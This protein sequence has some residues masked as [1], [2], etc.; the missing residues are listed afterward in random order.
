LRNLL[1]NALNYTDSG[2]QITLSAA[3]IGEEVVLSITDTGTGIPP[4]HLPHIFEK[5]SRVPG[6]SRGSGTGLGLAIV[7]EIITAHGGTITCESQPGT[8]TTFRISLPVATGG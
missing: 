4:E 8:G 3:A 7:H 2:G 1:D 5:F 6:H